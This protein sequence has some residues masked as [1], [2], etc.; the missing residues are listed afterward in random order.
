MPVTLL[1]NSSFLCTGKLKS[2]YMYMH[3][4]MFS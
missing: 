1:F 2:F 4:Y 3:E